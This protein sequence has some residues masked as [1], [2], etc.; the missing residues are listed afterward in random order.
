VARVFYFHK[1]TILTCL[2][3]AW[4][5]CRTRRV[6]RDRHLVCIEDPFEL[7]HDLG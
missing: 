4:L 3:T 5:G 1:S 7:S 6:E 2:Y